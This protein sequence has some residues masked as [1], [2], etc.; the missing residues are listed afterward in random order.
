MIDMAG[1]CKLHENTD[2]LPDEY[3]LSRL[4][5]SNMNCL[6]KQHI[7]MREE[8]QYCLQLVP[9][10]S[11]HSLCVKNYPQ[12]AIERGYPV[13]V[14]ITMMIKGKRISSGMFKE[15]EI[16]RGNMKAFIGA[17]IIAHLFPVLRAGPS[18]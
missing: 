12:L 3:G 4:M 17:Y 7:L 18:F 15:D 9:Q 2:V 14:A 6:D 8:E 11:V 10:M 1:S 16:A 5:R 13:D